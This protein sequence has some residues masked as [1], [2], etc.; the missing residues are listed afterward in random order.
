VGWANYGG[1]AGGGSGGGGA[2]ATG[3][4]GIVL[5]AHPVAFQ[6]ANAQGSNVSVTTAGGY[7]IYSFYSPGTITF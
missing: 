3:G 7:K 6:T 1:G 4:S 5:I 2:S